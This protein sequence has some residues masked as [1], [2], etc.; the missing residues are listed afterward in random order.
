M[1]NKLL[2]SSLTSGV[3]VSLILL[4]I[5]P[6]ISGNTEKM[7]IDSKD[8]I[9]A[10]S[11]MSNSYVNAYWKFN[12]GSGNTA[13]D[14]SG[15]DY[16]G[17]IYGASWT[18]D[19]PSGSGY[20]L[21]FD[22]V[23]DY[24]DLDIYASKI[25]FNKTDDLIFSFYIKTQS[26]QKGMIFSTSTSYGTNP[27]FHIFMAENG[28]IGV[29]A[30]VTSCGFT[31]YTNES[32]NDNQ[33]YNVEVWF[34]G[35]TNEPEVTI[36]VDNDPVA[37]IT[38][39]VCP[40]ESSEFKRTKLGRRSHNET[41]FFDGK[42]DELKIIKYPG[43][44]E[45]EPP[46]IEGPTSGD[47]G[48]EYDWT[49]TTEDPEEDEVWLWIKWGDGDED[50]W[51]GPYDSGE[52]AT[53][54]HTYDDEGEYYIEAQSKDVWHHS[55]WSDEYKVLIGNQPPDIPTI[56]GEKRYGSIGEELTFTI[57]SEDI[58]GSAIKYFVDWD[59][60]DTE[61]TNFY[62]SGQEVT[63][64]HTWDA[65][66]DYGITALAEDNQG[67][68][69]DLCE[70]LFIRIGDEPPSK[71]IIR[72]PYN[73]VPN[74]EYDFTFKSIDPEG[75]QVIYDIEWGD[76]SSV[77]DYGPF[78][79]GEEIELTHTYTSRDTFII[80][81][82]ATD[83]FGNPGEW[84]ERHITIPRSKTINLN[85]LEWLFVRFSNNFPIFKFLLSI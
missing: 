80:R 48:V 70:P 19:T 5:I 28:T 49:F 37:S 82:R 66:G 13:Y 25:A 65:N 23:N 35:I 72:G 73:G 20:A 71:P 9:P 64:K 8:E 44:N 55:K 69:S 53:F 36:F 81:A 43:G 42:I 45:Q 78:D 6:I 46:I 51:E 4:S 67:K 30:E 34:N 59:D 83:S 2:K 41:N 56:N 22:G 57:V 84:E 14:S 38:H 11:K 85:I 31:I 60:G 26:N 24:I 15:H 39:W 1:P 18:S 12:T 3:V 21:D 33:W 27:E 7:R 47:I 29:M 58:E 61:W 52:T 32:Y 68:Q 63:V 77:T 76:G 50:L 62:P 79:S 40:F 17:S 74:V 10:I 16:D 54:S 75:D